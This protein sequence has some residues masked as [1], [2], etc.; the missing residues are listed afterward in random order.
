MWCSGTSQVALPCE[1]DTD[2]PTTAVFAWTDS[3][4]VGQSLKVLKPSLGIGSP[5]FYQRWRQVPGVQNPA[6]C[7]SRGLFPLELKDY[8]LWWNEPQCLRLKPSHWPTQSTFSECVPCEEDHLQHQCCQS[9]EP[10]I[11]PSRY[12]SFTRLKRVT[13]WMLCF[14]KNVRSPTRVQSPPL[15]VSE[16]I[17]AETYWLRLFQRESFP[18]E[19]EKLKGEFPLPK[20]SKLLPFHLF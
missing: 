11:P 19:V 5:T 7:G 16:L 12:S 18:L 13:A 8:Q 15:T 9:S 2:I 3:T 10:R 20:N 4:I 1:E 17:T 6:D 14:T